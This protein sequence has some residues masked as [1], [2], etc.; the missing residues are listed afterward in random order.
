MFCAGAGV[1]GLVFRGPAVACSLCGTVT[2]SWSVLLNT[3]QLFMWRHAGSVTSWAPRRLPCIVLGYHD[4]LGAFMILLIMQ[5]P[6]SLTVMT[7]T[8]TVMIMAAR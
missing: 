6:L 5:Q 7:T 2:L 8:A 3:M 4:V 1:L